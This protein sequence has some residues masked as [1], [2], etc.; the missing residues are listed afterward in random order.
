MWSL[1]C[2]L[3]EIL[4]KNPMFPGNCTTNQLERILQF[5]EQPSSADIK[6]LQ[7]ELGEVMVSQVASLKLKKKVDLF[8]KI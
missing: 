1:G 5:T 8:T 4:I 2:I 7:T 3:G 6:A